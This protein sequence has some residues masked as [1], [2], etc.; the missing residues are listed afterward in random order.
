MLLDI[1]ATRPE[2]RVIRSGRATAPYAAYANATFPTLAEQGAAKEVITKQWDAV[3]G[4][5][6]TK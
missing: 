5:N 3:V 4:A 6:V 2:A 1:M